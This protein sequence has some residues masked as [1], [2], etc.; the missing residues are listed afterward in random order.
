MTQAH[1]SSDDS[2][3]IPLVTNPSSHLYTIHTRTGE[4]N[5]WL[6]AV[7]PLLLHFVSVIALVSAIHFYVDNHD[8]NLRSRT[9]LGDFTPLQSDIT[10]AISS[11]IA[12]LRFF[13]AMWSGSMILRCI[14]ILMER[15]RISLQEIDYL[16]TWQFH[17]H[18]RKE[19]SGRIGLF[20]AIILLA[21]FPCQLSGPILTGSITWIPSHRPS[22]QQ[23]VTDI[24]IG[25]KGN[26]SNWLEFNSSYGNTIPLNYSMP[27]ELSRGPVHASASALAA[28]YGS[29]DDE[30]IMKRT[31]RSDAQLPI[32]T[33]LNS[34]RLPYFAVTKLEWIRNSLT[35]VPREAKTRY[36]ETSTWNPFW[37]DGSTGNFMLL[38]DAWGVVAVPSDYNGTISK[39]SFIAGRFNGSSRNFN[40]SLSQSSV[41][42]IRPFGN[43]SDGIGCEDVVRAERTCI[44][45][46]RISYVAG[47]AECKN[48]RVSS[49]LTVA[50]HDSLLKL[51][52]DIATI[53]ALTMMPLVGMQLVQQN[54]SLPTTFQN[55]DKYVAELLIRSYAGSWNHVTRIISEDPWHLESDSSGNKWTTGAQIFKQ[56]SQ[57]EVLWWRVGLWVS[58]NLIFTLSGLLFLVIQSTC[59][60]PI[61]GSPFIAALFLDTTE[62]V[63]KRDRALCN[64]S[65]VVKKD[66]EI[67]YL[68]LRRKSFDDHHK[69]VEAV[70][71]ESGN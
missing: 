46:G 61:I 64:V 55:L 9:E 41:F 47:A 58:L 32:N 30:R 48:C 19:T 6:I 65:K 29:R 16:L 24:D 12:L 38:P 14:F 3:I 62:V 5:V 54:Y 45:Y 71:S 33:T 43:L 59:D 42:P 21:A 67:G 1:E 40:T 69:C 8:F 36:F 56:T 28:W 60:Q 26:H 53:Y 18:R 22:Y 63:H 27:S 66:K 34:I 35:E 39:T 44:I 68:R 4:G 15:D 20:V 70:D 13:A 17:I 52:P 51:E 57:A 37:V 23:N 11:S 31:I 2:D 7:I 49:L 10:T 25:Y 50:E